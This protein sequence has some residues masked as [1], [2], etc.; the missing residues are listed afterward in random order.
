MQ[1]RQCTHRR[2]RSL[3]TSRLPETNHSSKSREQAH[4]S[5]IYRK[6]VFCL[7]TSAV[8]FQ[9]RGPSS[10]ADALGTVR[11]EHRYCRVPAEFRPTRTCLAP[12]KQLQRSL[13][14]D[15][16]WLFPGLAR[17][18]ASAEQPCQGD[19]G[20]RSSLLFAISSR[21]ST[22]RWFDPRRTRLLQVLKLART[23]ATIRP[24]ICRPSRKCD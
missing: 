24:P 13:P 19:L 22:S 4:G 11:P 14:N 6:I 3:R 23:C 1:N 8:R 10:S 9:L 17:C 21:T 12:P 20:W 16:S 5:P 18:R 15:K 7:P 2:S